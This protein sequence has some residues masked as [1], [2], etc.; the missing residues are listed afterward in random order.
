[1]RRLFLSVLFVL[2]F[3]CTASSLPG[4]ETSGLFLPE[5]F[6]IS[7]FASG[8][9]GARFMAFNPDGVLYATLT[10]K[11]KVVALLDENK[12]GNAEKI[13]EAVSGLNNPHGIAF[14]KGYVYIAET[15]KVARFREDAKSRKFYDMKI[16]VPNLP[17]KGGGHFTRTVVFGPD[18]KMY[19]SAGS[20][21]NICEE[22]DERRAAILRF[23]PDGSGAELYARGLRNSVG[24]AFNP[25]TGGLFAAENGRDWL[26]DDLPPDEVNLIKEKRHYG[27][28]YCYGRRITDPEYDKVDFCMTTEPSLIDIQ[29]HSAPLGLR[30]YTGRKFPEKYRGALFMAL[31]GS[32]N[33][34]VPTGYKVVIAPFKDGMPSGAYEDFITGWLKEG[35]KSGRPVDIIEDKEGNLYIS[36]DYAGVIY[37]VG[38]K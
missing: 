3:S 18:G 9:E 2:A 8:I 25:V 29:A 23:N 20:S 22:E 36:D 26:G 5:G 38:Y 32:W 17:S 28:P 27:W 34:T 33:R 31:H 7:V 11:G 21:C 4:G 13:I 14:F 37:R 10:R 15:D 6:K 35:S 19:V 16:I 24:L 30:F 1:M 12:D